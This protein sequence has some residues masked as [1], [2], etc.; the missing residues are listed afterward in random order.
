LRPHARKA[1]ARSRWT[2]SGLDKPSLRWWRVRSR[3]VVREIGRDQIDQ[4]GDRALGVFAQRFDF[5]DAV[6]RCAQRHHFGD[7]FCIDPF[8]RVGGANGNLRLKLFGELG[9]LHRRPR[10]H[11]RGVHESHAAGNDSAVGALQRHCVLD[12]S[13]LA[14]PH[15]ADN[16]SATALTWSSELPPAASVAAI[17]AP[18]TIGA[19]QTTTRSRRSGCSISTAISLLV[20]APPRSTRIATPFG[21]HTLLMA[22]MINGTLVPRPPSGLPPQNATFTSVPT[23]CRTM[24]AVPL[25]MS[26]ECETMTIPTVSFI[27]A[28]PANCRRRGGER[29]LIVR[30]DRHARR[31]VHRETL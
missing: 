12:R 30:R 17:T 31:C 3:Y 21:D 28:P 10:M 25:A 8:G 15:A 14:R 27:P 2:P 19:L 7:A 1:H 18:S 16:S 11:A 5:D 9:Q 24:S 13:S 4:G 20:S 6:A 22:S 23:I 26:F 29:S